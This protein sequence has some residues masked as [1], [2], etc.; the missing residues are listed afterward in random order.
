[1]VALCHAMRQKFLPLE[2]RTEEQLLSSVLQAPG[3]AT[4]ILREFR[5]DQLNDAHRNE[6]GVTE[7]Q[8]DRLMAAIELGKRVCRFGES[9][10]KRTKISSSKDAI[11]YCKRHFADLIAEARQEEFHIV[12][13]NTKNVVIDSHQITVGTLDA[14]LVHPREV[15]RKA[16][17]DVCSSIILAHNHPSGDPTPSREDYA[18]T[19]RLEESGKV[20]GIDVLD[21][22]VMG[23]TG[24]VSLREER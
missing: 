16:I 8:Y 18:V 20:L 21:H 12:T 10:A 15:F 7:K 3:K 4:K 11:N 17:K 22:I 5:L 14:S 19:D 2:H 23:S 13:L 6:L 24:C 1:M 9:N